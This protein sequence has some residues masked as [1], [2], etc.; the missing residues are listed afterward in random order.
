MRSFIWLR[1][2]IAV[3]ALA[4][5]MVLLAEAPEPT[6]ASKPAAAPAPVLAG[7]VG[8]YYPLTTCF[9]TGVPLVPGERVSF[10]FEGRD[11]KVANEA[12]K[13]TFLADPKPYLAKLDAEIIKT[14]KDHYPLDKCPMMH[15]PVGAL[16]TPVD[17]V[18]NNQLLRTCCPTCADMAR[19]D[20][21]KW[22]AQVDKEIA[23]AQRPTY[24][25]AECVV[26]GHALGEMGAPVEVVEQGTLIRLCCK[27]C[28]HELRQ[29]P[30][31]FVTAVREARAKAAA[32]SASGS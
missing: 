26:A 19:K 24:P 7:P 30:G 3:V 31:K 1:T 25:L 20:P 29:D 9:V 27:G 13:Q 12:A 11:L 16:G 21:G 4:A 5:P 18:S 2:A 14:Q 17:V 22:Q 10:E 8:D 15:V 28:L 32:P 23:D 6:A